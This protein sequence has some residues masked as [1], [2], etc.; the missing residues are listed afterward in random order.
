M[1]RQL[2]DLRHQNKTSARDAKITLIKSGLLKLK[3]DIKNMPENE[4][5]HKG[6]NKKYC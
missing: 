4:V 1:V 2:K 6:F 5:K 3:T